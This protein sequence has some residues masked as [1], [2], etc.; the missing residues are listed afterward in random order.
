[1]ERIIER[2]RKIQALADRGEAGEAINAR[3]ILEAELKKAGLTIE[4]IL[5]DRRILRVFSYRDKDERN[6]FIQVLANVVG[7]KSEAFQKATFNRSSKKLFVDLTDLEYV[8]IKAMYD[9][10][11]AQFRKER[12]R[13]LKDLYRA[14]I[15]KHN[16]FDKDP[17]EETDAPAPG[18]NPDEILRI[19]RLVN[20]MEDVYFHKAL[21]Q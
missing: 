20:E 6:L 15:N 10:H 9:F 17:R 3:R 2:L 7:H 13:I 12:A 4:D 14:Y 19:L 18:I 5:S 21:T 16:L 1:M 11:L 8:D